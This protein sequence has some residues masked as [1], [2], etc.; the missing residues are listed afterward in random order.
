MRTLSRSLITVIVAIVVGGLAVGACIAAMIPGTVEVATAHHY[1]AEQVKELKA[2]AQPSTIYWADGTQMGQRIGLQARDPISSLREVPKIVQDA[3]IA[4]EDRSF[5]TNDGIDLGAVFRAFLTNVTSGKIEQGGSTITQQLVKNRILT[6]K[7]DVNRKIKEIEDALRLNEKFSKEKIFVEYLNTV[8]FGSGSYG[9]KAA[10][11][12]LFWTWDPGSPYPRGKRLD[13]LTLGEAALLAG[14]IQNP[15]GYS[16]FS[17]P[18][19]AIRRRADVLRGMVT[20]HY[21]TQAQA[22]AANNEP[23]P[24]IA[25]PANPIVGQDFLSSEVLNEL[26]QDPRL[27]GTEKERADKILKGG[28][29]IYTTFDPTLQNEAVAATTNNKPQMGADFVSS[30]VSMDP[31]TGAVKAMVSGQDWNES[32]TNIATSPDG[33]QTGS[34]FKVITLATALSNGYSP[35][36]IVNGNSPCSVAGFDGYTVNDEPGGGDIPIWEATQDSVNCA[37]VRIATS[38]GED[39]V[40]AMAHKM[41]ITKQNLEP[42]LTLTLGVF[43]QNTETMADVMSTIASGGVHHTPYVVQKIVFPDG[44]VLEANTAGDRVLD[45]DVAACEQNVLRKVVTS[46]TGTAADVPGHTIFGKTGTT[47]SQGDAWF[48]GATPQL[49]TAVWFGNWRVVQG[50]VGFGGTA[51]A[52]VFQAF[53]SQALANQPNVPL[54]DPGPVCARTS[55]N[56]IET[57]GRTANAPVQITP[58]LPTV[59]QQPTSPATPTTPPTAATTPIIAVPGGRQTGQ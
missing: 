41:G 36:D 56:V 43:G 46:G 26:L 37:F 17:N 8:Y 45:P 11:S 5:W 15:E 57:G 30:L 54:P 39:K 31:N 51:A 59:Q 48:I 22:D 16:P 2:L 24:K 3:V 50:P 38:V 34:T 20:E 7:R 32:Q 4:T 49:A 13:E 28:L 12:R 10:A 58:Q 52:P 19:R 55:Q 29:K 35:D 9:I 18:D 6:S 40:I 21:I 1:T 44:K 53:M 27:G 47:D 23:I 42:Y 14:L 33:R 25:P